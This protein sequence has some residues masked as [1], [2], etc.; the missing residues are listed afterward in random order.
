MIGHFG[1]WLESI[2]RTMKMSR[3]A[4]T[5]PLENGCLA[6]LEHHHGEETGE[7]DDNGHDD[8]IEGQL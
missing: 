1:D 5:I 4:E 7:K 2:S 6:K 3:M 8:L